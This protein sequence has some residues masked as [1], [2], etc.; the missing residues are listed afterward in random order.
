MERPIAVVGAGVAGSSAAILLAQQGHSVI[1][2]EK[3]SAP[4]HK[5][6]GEFLSFECLSW[7]KELGVDLEGLGAVPIESFHV[8]A[9]SSHLRGRLPVPGMSL[10]RKKLDSALIHR[11]QELG[12]QFYQGHRLLQYRRLAKN[13]FLLQTSK[14]E[15]QASALFWATG[16][17]DVAKV[18]KRV[19]LE[20]MSIAFKSHLTLSKD[21]MAPYQGVIDLHLYP[22]GYGGISQ[23]ENGQMNFCC[24]IGR[25]KFKEIGSWR[26]LLKYQAEQ[27][28]RLRHIFENCHWLW[29]K[30]LTIANIPYGFRSLKPL[31][32]VFVLGDQYAVISSLTGDG[33]SIAF[34]SALRAVKNFCSEKDID[35]AV[36]KYHR[37]MEKNLRFPLK[38]GYYLHKM[39]CSRYLSRV[40]IKMIRPFPQV[41]EKLVEKTRSSN[42]LEA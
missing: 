29:D 40:G 1:V 17:Y 16:K 19:G 9:G 8:Y 24:I 41:V 31:P 21:L 25:K 4:H 37:E 12:V 34:L 13:D 7:I 10:S 30:P 2:I 26:E 35:R 14:G 27:S 20:N 28:P 23:V 38:I 32:G 36:E 15:F 18:Q 11:A 33:M 5:V 6:C 39:F 42:V 3:A 22:G